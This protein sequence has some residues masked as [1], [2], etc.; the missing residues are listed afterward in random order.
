LAEIIFEI[1]LD[2]FFKICY[3]EIKQNGEKMK[4]LKFD[5]K[6]LER[7]ALEEVMEALS[8]FESTGSRSKF[9]DWDN[10]YGKIIQKMKDGM[11]NV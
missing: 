9:K 8:C 10:K 6:I 7:R 5:C 2:K 3:N 11:I 4:V 1:S